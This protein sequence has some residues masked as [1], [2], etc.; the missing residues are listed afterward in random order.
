MRLRFVPLAAHVAQDLKGTW[1]TLEAQADGSVN[2]TFAM[3]D[4][5]W[6]ASMALGFGP[7]V[8]VLEPAANSQCRQSRCLS[9]NVD[10][11]ARRAHFDSV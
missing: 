3:P 5:E 8:T 10:C 9:R 7:I 1:E 4:V 2:V 6:A 11:E